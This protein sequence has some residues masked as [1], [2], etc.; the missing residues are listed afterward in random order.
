MKVLRELILPHKSFLESD[1]SSALKD[2]REELT[3]N[4]K[5]WYNMDPVKQSKTIERDIEMNIFEIKFQM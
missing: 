3:E 1:C 4:I 5:R 2:S